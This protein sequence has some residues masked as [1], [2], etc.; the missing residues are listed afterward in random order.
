MRAHKVL[1][2]PHGGLGAARNVGLDHCTGHYVMLLDADDYLLGGTAPALL[3]FAQQ[4]RPDILAYGMKKVYATVP[5]PC[6]RRA[7]LHLCY[8]GS[9]AAIWR[10]ITCVP[11]LG[12]ISYGVRFWGGCAFLKG[13]IMRTRLLRLACGFVP[14]ACVSVGCQYMPIISGLILSCM[15]QDAAFGA[16]H[17]TS[18]AGVGRFA[19]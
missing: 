16:A 10:A 9:G 12:A 1:H 2:P 19:P 4:R 17:G 6:R 18:E 14:V 11:P 8:E 15:L 7:H 3:A 13:C 5:L